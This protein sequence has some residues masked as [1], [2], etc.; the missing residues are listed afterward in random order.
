MEGIFVQIFHIHSRPIVQ[1]RESIWAE[2]QREI[3]GMLTGMNHM[4]TEAEVDMI[5]V[6]EDTMIAF[7]DTNGKEDQIEIDMILGIVM[8]VM[9]EIEIVNV[10]IVNDMNLGH[11]RERDMTLEVVVRQQTID[12]TIEIVIT[13]T[14]TTGIDAKG[15]FL[16]FQVFPGK[17]HVL[18][19]ETK[20]RIL[21]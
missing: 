11:M 19:Q 14:D 15:Y 1:R 13:K 12:M 7:L 3:V 8:I 6:I 4:T 17:Y 9:K 20:L 5:T 18:F 21:T 16:I 10:M 2:L